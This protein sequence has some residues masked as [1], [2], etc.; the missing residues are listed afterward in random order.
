MGIQL[1]SQAT[2]SAFRVPSLQNPQYALAQA[3]DALTAAAAAEVLAPLGAVTRAS[4]S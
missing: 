2:W 1:G 4:V 3:F